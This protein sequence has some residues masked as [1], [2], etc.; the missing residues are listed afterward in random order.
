MKIKRKK[1]IKLIKNFLLEDSQKIDIKYIDKVDEDTGI[2]HDNTG[3]KYTVEDN[4][5]LED[6]KSKGKI[7]MY[8]YDMDKPNEE[9][10]EEVPYEEFVKEYSLV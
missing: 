7:V 3:I 6:D 4:I 8:R 9:I 5:K 1:L 10:Y 2:K